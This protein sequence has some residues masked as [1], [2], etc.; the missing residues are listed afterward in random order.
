MSIQILA[1]PAGV[2]AG[3]AG[4]LALV[5]ALLSKYFAPAVDEKVSQVSDALPGANC[6]AC[7]FA[8]CMS[9][10]EAV[11]AGNASVN[12]CIPG[13]ESV[14]AGISSI[15]GISAIAG[16]KRIAAVACNGTPENTYNIMDYRGLNTCEAAT[17][18]YGGEKVCSYACLGHGDCAVK[19]P[20]G[21]IIVDDGIAKINKYICTGCGICVETCPKHVIHLVEAD[22]T[23][24]IKCSNHDS[25]KVANKICK[26]S[27]IA[28]RKCVRL[29]GEENIRLYDNLAIVNHDDAG[30]SE[31]EREAVGVC[32][33]NTITYISMDPN[34]PTYN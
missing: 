19:C 22:G 14:T 20:F 5:L 28:C 29:C 3:L 26:T 16:A 25:P 13:G 11:C 1:L 7:G 6:G 2:A 32:P 31:Y 21:A 17:M 15:L 30:V 9:F 27:C 34:D 23:A 18:F 4:I 12:G 10:A 8:G 33:H 24:F